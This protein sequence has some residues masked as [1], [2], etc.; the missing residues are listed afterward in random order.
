MSSDRRPESMRHRCVRFNRTKPTKPWDAILHIN[1]KRRSLGR[2]A[3]REEAE[4]ACR[5]VR[6]IVP[7]LPSGRPRM[8]E[9]KREAI[10][11]TYLSTGS[12]KKTAEACGV[13]VKTVQRLLKERGSTKEVDP[14]PDMAV[15][16][17]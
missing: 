5:A 1:G 6:K 14:Y 8:P 16:M 4:A 11:N 13:N 12:Q 3:T 7:A 17:A 9:E 15:G 10:P 2:Y